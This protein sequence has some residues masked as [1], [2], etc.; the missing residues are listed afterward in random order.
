M[1]VRT[2]DPTDP[3]ASH[4]WTGMG[5]VLSIGWP[6]KGSRNAVGADVA[7]RIAGQ[8]ALTENAEVRVVVLGADQ[9]PFCSGWDVRDL[10]GLDTSR[11]EDVVRYFEAGRELLRAIDACPVPV[12]TAVSGFALGF[13]C[14]I[15]A[16]SDVVLADADA[17]FGLPEIKRGFAPATVMPELLEAM[18]A[19]EIRAWALT[20]GRYDVH[21]ASSAGL[22]H[23]IAPAGQLAAVLTETVADLVGAE[24][25]VLRQTKA[26]LRE[27]QALPLPQRRARG[28]AAAIDHFCK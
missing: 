24:P 27:Q 23:R 6:D 9:A 18:D 22:V 12:V 17:Q 25:A 21:R 16:H 5:G 10:A 13:G 20:G 11:R 19:R 3:G 7:R 2:D 8:L 28:V 4:P 14:S 15:L 26:L 1:T